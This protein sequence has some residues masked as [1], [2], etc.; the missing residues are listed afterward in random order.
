MIIRFK[1]FENIVSYYNHKF[2]TR[3]NWCY[4]IFHDNSNE[5]EYNDEGDE[6]CP[7]CGEGGY[8][9]DIYLDEVGD[10]FEDYVDN[11][12]PKSNIKIEDYDDIIKYYQDAYPEYF[13][14][15]KYNL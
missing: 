14:S 1:L 11:N 12:L 7:K 9:M 4:G 2:N 5:F 6:V 13:A 10:D 8:L 3:C 15:K